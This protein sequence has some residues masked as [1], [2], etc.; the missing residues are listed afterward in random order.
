MSYIARRNAHLDRM[1]SSIIDA[2]IRYF[3]ANRT[4]AHQ[5]SIIERL[6]SCFTAEIAGLVEEATGD[7]DY[8]SAYPEHM[9]D[10]ARRCFADAAE[11][12]AARREEAAVARRWK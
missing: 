11:S 6:I 10:D 8:M 12:E 2:K 3:G 1:Q 9:L 5:Q 4:R 7:A